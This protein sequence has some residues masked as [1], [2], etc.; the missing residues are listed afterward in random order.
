MILWFLY[1]Q[2]RGSSWRCVQILIKQETVA[3]H[4]AL[5]LKQVSGW[6]W[7]LN[8]KCHLTA[9]VSLLYI[10]IELW[11]IIIVIIS[12]ILTNEAW[13]IKYIDVIRRRVSAK[14]SQLAFLWIKS[15]IPLHTIFITDVDQLLKAIAATSQ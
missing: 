3:W 11:L 10:H 1:R 4:V 12:L 15:D 6:Y 14:T 5:Y 13:T 2:F 9:E 8:F 7:P